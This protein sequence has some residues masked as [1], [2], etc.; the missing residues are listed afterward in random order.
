MG[1]RADRTF[2]AKPL[3][4]FDSACLSGRCGSPG[5]ASC[6]A[7]SQRLIGYLVCPK[8]LPVQLDPASIPS[9]SFYGV[10]MDST[11]RGGISHPVAR[12]ESSVPAA[13]AAAG[14]AGA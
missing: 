5:T 7:D 14:D 10:H 6:L 9:Y 2:G 4:T 13:P 1:Q 8:G 3:H 12:V 11:T